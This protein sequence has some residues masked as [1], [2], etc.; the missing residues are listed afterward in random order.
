MIDLDAIETCTRAGMTPSADVVLAMVDAIR[1][2]DSLLDMQRDAIN[3]GKRLVA[4]LE[5][6]NAQLREIV[7]GSSRA[8]EL[9]V[10]LGIIDP[11]METP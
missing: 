11:H 5:R 9:K 6:E 8:S 4:A 2:R 7:N 3:T 1:E 10:N